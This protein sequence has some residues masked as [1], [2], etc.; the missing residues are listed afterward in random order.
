MLED[1]F[2]ALTN[3]IIA[4]ILFDHKLYANEDILD[5][6]KPIKSLM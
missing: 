3:T 6:L 2:K 4:K 1:N 5:L